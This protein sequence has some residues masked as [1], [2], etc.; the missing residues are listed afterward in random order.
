MRRC[1][2]RV[3]CVFLRRPVIE[4]ESPMPPRAY[5]DVPWHSRRNLVASS[6]SRLLLSGVR[7]RAEAGSETVTISHG[8]PA[9]SAGR[10]GARAADR[11]KTGIPSSGSTRP[12]PDSER[13]K[14]TAAERPF[15]IYD[16]DS[17]RCIVSNVENMALKTRAYVCTH[18]VSSLK[19][20][21]VVGCYWASEPR[22]DA[23]RDVSL[24]PSKK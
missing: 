3:C 16:G 11:A 18:L 15:A 19:T 5:V 2:T 13:T 17:R 14:L 4:S 22:G 23:W 12:A 8:M 9:Q 24:D 21:Q 20:Q 1:S 10:V 6:A 7:E